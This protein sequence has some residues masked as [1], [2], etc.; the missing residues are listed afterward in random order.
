MHRGKIG[1]LTALFGIFACS[2]AFAL[3]EMGTKA[4][5]LS[6]N[7]VR[8]RFG[9]KSAIEERAVMPMTDADTPLSTMNDAKSA[10]AS[11]MCGQSSVKDQ[12]LALQV[13]VNSGSITVRSDT[14]GDGS[15]DSV[16]VF[17]STMACTEGY[18]AGTS[19][20]VWTVTGTGFVSSA[21]APPLNGCVSPE[22]APPAYTGGKIAQL[23]A[24]ATGRNITGSSTTG[25]TVKYYAG[26]VKNCDQE[27]Q[28]ISATQYYD[29]P[30]MMESDATGQT[31]ACT[32][33]AADDMSCEAYKGMVDANTNYGSSLTGEVNCTITREIVESA[34]P[35]DR[36]ICEA[37][38]VYYPNGYSGTSRF[39]MPGTRWEYNSELFMRCGP[40]GKRLTV[41]GWAYWE[42]APCGVDANHPPPMQVTRAV[43][44]G[45]SGTD[46]VV[47]EFSVN[48]RMDGENTTSIDI[49]GDVRCY[50]EVYP[51]KVH[52]TYACG[53]DDSYCDYTFTVDNAPSCN[54]F[55]VRVAPPPGDD[56]DNGCALYEESSSISCRLLN[57]WW[58]DANG[59]SYKTV[60]DGAPT[61]NEVPE[62]CKTS[63]VHGTVC[64][65]W[66]GKERGYQCEIAGSQSPDMSRPATVIGSTSMSGPTIT[67]NS[68]ECTGADCKVETWDPSLT[69][70]EECE[71][72][73]LVKRPAGAE[74]K[75]N[76][77]Y[78]YE[79]KIC[80]SVTAGGTTSYACPTV[81]GDTIIQGCGCIDTSSM[82]LGTMG[83][84]YEATR[85]RTCNTN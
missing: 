27:P 55:S 31:Y 80:K 66:W 73:C 85:D 68:P 46:T 38:K 57:E 22:S 2:L 56:I 1:V 79:V 82:S 24:E 75:G 23:Y 50:G 4:G 21:P 40:Y 76:S 34:G 45:G 84:I 52:M 83:A 51:L 49:G 32:S 65:P 58:I 54:A 19:Y 26:T 29:N 67:Y 71:I 35:H 3:D 47:G 16:Q 10:N 48:R 36:I 59:A 41:E 37:N 39:C 78:D 13:S 28:D 11:V 70:G 53:P 62:T 9:T 42:G 63:A 74:K 61:H 17:N 77:S 15:L 20:Y 6:G 7:Y 72:S 8:K 81:A 14:T 30:Y 18:Q 64:K 33:S 60:R 69:S 25:E 12:A 43:S 44:Y 5:E